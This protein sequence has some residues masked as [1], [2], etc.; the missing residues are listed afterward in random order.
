MAGKMGIVKNG[1]LLQCL[2]ILE[3]WVYSF[4]N[5]VIVISEGMKSI[6]E[7]KGVSPKKVKVIENFIDTEFITPEP[8]DN[9]FSRK[10]GL[11]DRFVVMYAGNIGIPHGVEVLIEAA[12]ML[13]LEKDLVFCFLGRGENRHRIEFLARQ[14]GLTN[15]IFI[16]QQ[17]EDIVPL[18]WAT[19]SVGIITYR[20]GLADF[21]VPSKLLAMM[22]A[23]RPAIASVDESSD[24]AK[25]IRKS[26]CGFCVQ[27][28]DPLALVNAIKLLYEDKRL[29]EE[30]GRNGRRYVEENLN[31][32]V[33]SS[34]YEKL[35]ADLS[36]SKNML[37][38]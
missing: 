32:E 30:M 12:E 38:R 14:K 1:L 27:S 26:G 29:C 18:I 8:R 34:H 35:F 11:H 24:T 9:L 6:I 15:S 28:E 16:D 4:S 22:C 25:F 17:P 7:Q 33:V 10:Y 36:C 19:A 13:Q 31:R 23:A 37:K 5:K 21:S 2:L 3:K 20:K